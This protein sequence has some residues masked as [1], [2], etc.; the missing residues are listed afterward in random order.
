MG[1]GAVDRKVGA[2]PPENL[3][4]VVRWLVPAASREHV[5]G[6]LNE[7]YRSP[8]KYLVDALCVLPFVIASQVRRSS[9]FTRVAFRAFILWYAAFLGPRQES[10]LAATLPT[11]LATVAL[12]LRDAYRP[13][14]PSS[15]SPTPPRAAA[16]DVALVCASVLLV[17]TVVALWAPELL[18]T[19]QA[20][21][22]G[23]PFGCALLF[24]TRLQNPPRGIWAIP[25]PTRLSYT[26]LLAEVRGYEAV[27]QR[28]LRIEIVMAVALVPIALLMCFP[29]RWLVP[30]PI[31][32]LSF[33]IIA[34]GGA[35][36]ALLL[37]K[38]M[39]LRAVPEGLSFAE[40][41]ARYRSNLELRIA[42]ARTFVWWYLVPVLLGPTVLVLDPILWHPRPLAMPIA[43]V[44][45]L[46][47]IIALILVARRASLHKYKQRIDQLAVV[48]ENLVS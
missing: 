15:P 23:I 5:V 48:A 19:R 30:S 37:H 10:W 31:A 13:T 29:L 25:A 21:I 17:E 2:Q 8:G 47:V 39:R 28:A 22:Y 4:K 18:L 14:A 1:R 38:R 45:A 20:F 35:F 6:D 43:G 44:I 7:R 16:V 34:A 11:V 36:V 27:W 3:E 32:R 9:S 33:A 42:H 26:E 40:T 12:I 46:V 41:V 24:I